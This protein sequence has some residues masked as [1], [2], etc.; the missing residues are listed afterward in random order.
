MKK[1]KL[2]KD[3]PWLEV[4]TI[5][6]YNERLWL[7]EEDSKGIVYNYCILEKIIVD[8]NKE[9]LEEILSWF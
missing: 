7:I 5:I 2:L 3:L 4:G 1:F 6:E 8:W 9:W